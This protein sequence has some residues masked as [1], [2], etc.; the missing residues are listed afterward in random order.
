MKAKTISHFV[1]FLGIC[2]LSVS[3][4]RADEII[5][6][7]FAGDTVNFLGVTENSASLPPALY[8]VPQIS[9]DTLQYLNPG[10]AG[11]LSETDSPVLTCSLAIYHLR[12]RL[13]TDF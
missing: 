11:F 5:Y 9:V 4:L 2:L 1:L 13:R 12:L 6:G 7:D 8:G 10:P 3:S